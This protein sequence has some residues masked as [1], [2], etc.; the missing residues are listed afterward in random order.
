MVK[1]FVLG[2]CILN[3]NARAPGIAIWRGVVEPIYEVLK[4]T[5]KWFIQLPCPE[6]IYLGLRRWWFV[7]EQYDNY[8][9]RKINHEL[10][11]AIAEILLEHGID[12]VKIVGLGLSPSCAVRET[13]SDETWGGMPRNISVNNIK[14]GKGVWI[15]VLE[16]VFR[17][18]GLDYI[19]YDIPPAIIY[20]R[21]RA[22]Y[23][24]KYPVDF[25]E[26]MIEVFREFECSDCMD[27]LEKYR[28]RNVENDLRSGKIIAA[29]QSLVSSFDN[30]VEEHVRSGYGIVMIPSSNE[31]S[32]YK[33]RLVE[34]VKGH[35]LNHVKV[36]HEVKI[37][38]GR[39]S[40]LYD[41]LIRRITKY[42]E[43]LFVFI[44]KS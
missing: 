16:K 23:S 17:G 36:G 39:F 10:A 25:T 38:Y 19:Q 2:H 14:E 8:L 3:M 6:S 28:A 43:K 20:P 11:S 22:E 12:S 35:L 33:L 40:K 21:G 29:P 34:H 32:E 7:K 27:I 4:R 24:H 9:F 5:S 18:Y 31:L 42:N 13:Q 41:E 30:M 15:E 1:G 44:P 37:I 26:A